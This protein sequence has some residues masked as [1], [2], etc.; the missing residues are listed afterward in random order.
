MKPGKLQRMISLFR[1]QPGHVIATV[2]NNI[3]KMASGVSWK[4]KFESKILVLA[5]KFAVNLSNIVMPGDELC[6]VWLWD[7]QKDQRSGNMEV[8][9]C[10]RGPQKNGGKI[11]SG[12]LRRQE[13]LIATLIRHS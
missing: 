1:F 4:S 12:K 5:V 2:H 11:G 3:F 10:K 6:H 7:K 13:K 8:T 9:E